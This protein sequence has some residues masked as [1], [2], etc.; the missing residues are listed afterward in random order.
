VLLRLV[1]RHGLPA[2][3]ACGLRWSQIDLDQGVIY[4]KRV[5]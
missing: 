1:Y 2:S 5:K 4:V 3:E